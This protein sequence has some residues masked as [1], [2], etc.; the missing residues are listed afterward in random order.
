MAIKTAR[1]TLTTTPAQVDTAGDDVVSGRALT[2][3][4]QASGTIVICDGSGTDPTSAGCRVPVSSGVGVS[5]DKL[6]GDGEGVWLAVG[7]GTLA[8]DVV[9]IGVS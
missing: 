2:V 7:S 4:P 3:F 6:R 5:F 1:Y 8:V 9:E